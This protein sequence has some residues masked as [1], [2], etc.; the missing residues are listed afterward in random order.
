MTEYQ[1]DRAEQDLLAVI[2]ELFA[3][4]G[5]I[6]RSA[7]SV[8]ARGRGLEVAR[9]FV[10]LKGFGLIEEFERKPFFL[11]RL[12]GAVPLA[13]VRPTEAG[14]AYQAAAPQTQPAP[15]PAPAPAAAATPAPAP[16]QPEPTA[17]SPLIHPVAPDAPR[18]SW[19]IERSAPGLTDFTEDLGGAPIETPAL[20]LDTGAQAGAVE[21]I[22]ETLRALGME[23]TPAGEALA[24]QRLSGGATTGEAL[25]QVVLF[26]IA[27]AVQ[28]DLQSGGQLLEFGLHDYAVEVM[29]EIEKLRDGGELRDDLFEQDMRQVWALVQEGAKRGA[30][31]AEILKDPVGG[32]APTALLPEELRQPEEED[33]EDRF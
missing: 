1:L 16:V 31:A 13:L 14:A 25:S 32:A 12:F 24:R 5:P 9:P 15:K 6:E 8:E 30:L 23:I 26:A 20:Q 21:D 17:I 18:A 10:R 11:R 27:H 3:E 22:G 4:A 19:P 28:H 29:R 2:K 7:L 33:D